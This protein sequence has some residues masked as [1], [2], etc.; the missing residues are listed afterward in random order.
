MSN[1]HFYLHCYIFLI[2]LRLGLVKINPAL[3]YSS[4]LISFC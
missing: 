1:K 4:L 2:L 3:L